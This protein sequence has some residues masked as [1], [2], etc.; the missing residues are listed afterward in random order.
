MLYEMYYNMLNIWFLQLMPVKCQTQ[1]DRKTDH[2][3]KTAMQMWTRLGIV[4]C[5]IIMQQQRWTLH[6]KTP[7]NLFIKYRWI[8]QLNEDGIYIHIL[9]MSAFLTTDCRD[10]SI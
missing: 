10:I 1:T 3:M 4:L 6:L 9:N 8:M 7:F 2:S 5:K